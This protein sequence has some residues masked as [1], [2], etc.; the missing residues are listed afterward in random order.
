MSFSRKSSI[1]SILTI[2]LIFISLLSVW[3]CAQKQATAAPRPPWGEAEALAREQ[4]IIVGRERFKQETDSLAQKLQ[5]KL[6]QP[7]P[8]E[9]RLRGYDLYL[10]VNFLHAWVVAET[11]AYPEGQPMDADFLDNVWK[12][13]TTH[14]ALAKAVY[15]D[16]LAEIDVIRSQTSEQEF[17]K[18][19][20]HWTTVYSIGVA[21]DL[22]ALDVVLGRLQ[23]LLSP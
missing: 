15:P 12:P 20:N 2:S 9:V 14:A 1:L 7:T 18:P 19:G 8:D 22:K 10:F 23:L 5:Q 13:I 6:I 16:L 17:A 3:G 4:G 21:Q 11:R